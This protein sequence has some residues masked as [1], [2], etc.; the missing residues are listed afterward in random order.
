MKTLFLKTIQP[1][2]KTKNSNYKLKIIDIKMKKIKLNINKTS[3]LEDYKN[4]KL[5]KLHFLSNK[6]TLKL[7]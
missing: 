4:F 7:N 3:L 1:N 2:L 5:R 6:K